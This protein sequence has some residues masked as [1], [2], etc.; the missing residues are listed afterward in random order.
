MLIYFLIIFN[1]SIKNKNA[2]NMPITLEYVS[3][4][5][6]EHTIKS[7]S[8]SLFSRFIAKQNAKSQ[9]KTV[10]K[11]LHEVSKIK[12]GKKKEITLDEFLSTF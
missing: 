7:Q 10:L 3:A 5:R 6:V 2:Q 9:A 8:K 11:G 4:T 12:S 1:I